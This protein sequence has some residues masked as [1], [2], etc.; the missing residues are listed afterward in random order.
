MLQLK[1]RRNRA[2]AEATGKMHLVFL[3]VSLLL[4]VS[5]GERELVLTVNRSLL[6]GPAANSQQV[7]HASESLGISDQRYVLKTFHY[8]NPSIVHDTRNKIYHRSVL[9][10][11]QF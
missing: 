9:S 3:L 6:L 2:A 4:L 7:F 1:T 10:S 8:R 5:Y 11:S